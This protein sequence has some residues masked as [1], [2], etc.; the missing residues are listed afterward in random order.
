M[1]DYRYS[2]DKNIEINYTQNYTSMNYKN[3][4]N[5]ASINPSINN[6]KELINFPSY[7]TRQFKE[8]KNSNKLKKLNSKYSTCYN[9]YPRKIIQ[10]F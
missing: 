10:N 8:E 7:N 5:I 1:K 2:L 3:N 4:S 9:Y 6:K